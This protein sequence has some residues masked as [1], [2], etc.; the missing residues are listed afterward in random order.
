MDKNFISKLRVLALFVSGLVTL[1]AFQ[2]CGKGA[3]RV[4]AIAASAAPTTIISQ[5]EAPPPAQAKF[6]PEEEPADKPP[7]GNGGTNPNFYTSSFSGAALAVPEC[8]RLSPGGEDADGNL[9]LTGQ[10]IARNSSVIHATGGKLLV[11]AGNGVVDIPASEISNENGQL[12]FHA[13]KDLIASGDL[14]GS[15][16]GPGFSVIVGECD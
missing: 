9:I 14:S 3:P 6:E 12:E 5:E 1:V 13:A 10:L 2:N 4:L 16:V 7:D 15:F 8:V 11:A